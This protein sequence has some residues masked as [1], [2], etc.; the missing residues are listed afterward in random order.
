MKKMLVRHSSKAPVLGVLSLM[1]LCTLA[2]VVVN[3][4]TSSGVDVAVDD[5]TSLEGATSLST[6][7]PS[8]TLTAAPGPSPYQTEEDA[9]T[10][11]RTNLINVQAALTQAGNDTNSQ[12]AAGCSPAGTCAC[13]AS[14]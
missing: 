6:S 2:F 3:S 14:L 12:P 8:E 11:A 10:T 4:V 7:T 13:C 9:V 1:F 5:G